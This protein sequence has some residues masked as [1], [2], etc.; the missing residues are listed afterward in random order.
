MLTRHVEGPYFA[1]PRLLHPELNGLACEEESEAL[2]LDL[3]LVHKHVRPA[4]VGLDEPEAL[5]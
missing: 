4:G 2:S 1:V 5:M 3:R